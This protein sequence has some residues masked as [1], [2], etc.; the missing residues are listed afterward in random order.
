MIRALSLLVHGGPKVGKTT[1]AESTPAPR[2]VLDAEGGTRFTPTRKTFWDPSQ[3]APPEIDG[4]WETCIVYVRDYETIERVYAWLASGRHPFKSVVMDSISEVQQR[5][6]DTLVGTDQM[7]TQDWGELLRKVSDLTRK[8]RDLTIHPTNPLEAVVLVAMTKQDRDKWIPFM[9]GSV[10]T[11]MP[12]YTDVVGYLYT[13]I[14]DSGHYARRL[15]VAP[16]PQFE[17]GDRT[18]R[19]PSVV[20][21]GTDPTNP[22][23][24]TM[25]SHVYGP[26]PEGEAT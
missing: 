2:L 9:Q 1:L 25:L 10:K 20:D 21:C 8:M 22:T 17:A 5:C 12:Y 13:E 6:I 18:G 7:R 19:L 26:R 11:V 14:T 4:S 16:H 3:Y 23:W 15:L 24:E